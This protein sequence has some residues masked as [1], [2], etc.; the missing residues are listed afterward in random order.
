MPSR[1]NPLPNT[2][3]HFLFHRERCVRVRTTANTFI[4]HALAGGRL[5]SE[6]R[7]AAAHANVSI[8]STYLHVAVDDQAVRNLFLFG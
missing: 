3:A 7:D 5:L 2:R 4:S 8:A 6:V 1:A